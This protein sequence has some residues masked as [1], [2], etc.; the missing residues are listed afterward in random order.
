MRVRRIRNK[1]LG[2]VILIVVVSITLI[3][4]LA[5][6]RFSSILEN[7][8]L[9]EDLI[10]VDQTA[11]QIEQ[12]IEDVTLYAGNMVNDE[13]LQS[14]AKRNSYPS[15]YEEIKAYQQVVVQ[16]TK[17]NVLRNYLESSAI[18]RNDGKVF[19]SSL[20]LDPYFERELGKSWYRDA[21]GTGRKSGFTAPHTISVS[22]GDQKVVSFYI[23]FAPEYGGVLLLNIRYDAIAKLFDS[24]A[25]SFERYAWMNDGGSTYLLNRNMTHSISASTQELTDGEVTVH[26]QR[27]GYYLTRSFKETGWSVIT[28]TSKGRF[29]RLLGYVVQYWAIF[30]TLC[31]GLCVLLFLPIISN[32]TRPISQMS[33]AMKMVSMGNYNVGLQFRSNDELDILRTGFQS[34]LRD[35]ELQIEEKVQQE[36]WKKRVSTE[37][38]LAQMNP[39]FIYNTLNTVIY[40]SRKGNNKAVEEM[41]EAFIGILHDAVKLGESG[42]FIQAAKEKELIDHYVLIQKYRYID[43]FDLVWN[44]KEEMESVLIPKSVLQPLV[45]NAIFHGFAELES[46]GL[47]EITLERTED[48]IILKVRDNGTGMDPETAARLLAGELPTTVRHTGPMK[49]I[50][51]TN[52][53]ERLTYLYGDAAVFKLDTNEGDGT[54]IVITLPLKSDVIIESG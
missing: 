35:I 14:F 1:I 11:D 23:R 45:E 26:H 32:I 24:L 2:S 13:L 54:T 41:V 12:F 25:P 42:L 15:V 10:H 37:L 49:H 47:I 39:H 40:L 34:M 43:K 30:L 29:Y 8:A 50:G 5:L 28:Y 46:P 17:F 6:E 16:L 22:S 53:R 21:I 44:M 3:S 52:I 18:V 7:Q 48:Y 4:V 31:L 38:L 20:Y 27:S 9:K 51:I 36:K 33:K 19:W